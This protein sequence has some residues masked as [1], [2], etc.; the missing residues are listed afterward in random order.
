MNALD[1]EQLRLV[2]Q[3]C[4][5]N[6]ANLISLNRLQNLLDQHTNSKDN[7]HQQV[8]CICISNIDYNHD[9]ASF[10]QSQWLVN[11]LKMFGIKCFGLLGCPS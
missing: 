6:D 8:I 11:L 7:K 10:V 5:P 3:L 1:G 2:F 4:Q 9:K